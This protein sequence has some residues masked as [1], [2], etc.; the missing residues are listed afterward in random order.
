MQTYQMV[1]VVDHF[2]ERYLWYFGVMAMALTMNHQGLWGDPQSIRDC[3][4]GLRGTSE[5]LGN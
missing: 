5:G 4:Y 2:V 1:I 3:K